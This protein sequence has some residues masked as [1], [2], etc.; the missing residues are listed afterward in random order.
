MSFLPAFLV[1]GVV[2]VNGFSYL[3][4]LSPQMS[5]NQVVND[6]KTELGQTK[7][8]SGGNLHKL[9]LDPSETDTLATTAT[10]PATVTDWKTETIAKTPD[11]HYAKD[12]P[13]AGW[14]G[15]KHP[16]YGGY[17]EHL[18][19]QNDQ[20]GDVTAATWD[21]PDDSDSSFT[22]CV[23]KAGKKAEYGDDI[24]WGAQVYLDTLN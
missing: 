7:L 24:R 1:V 5:P 15:Y 21:V 20:N 19:D 14:A 8:D 11:D 2:E 3:D 12:H 18:S 22:T 6:N 23:L 4:S 13:G 9:T 10:N 16:M 17:L